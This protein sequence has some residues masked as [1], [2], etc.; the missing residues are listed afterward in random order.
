MDDIYLVSSEFL[1]E[2]EIEL[3]RMQVWQHE[4][5]SAEAL[6]SEQPFCLDMLGFEQWL[7]FVF[8]ER[9]TQLIA[10]RQELPTKFGLAPMSEQYFASKGID[11]RAL[12]NLLKRLDEAL[13]EV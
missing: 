5:P 4:R 1:F 12:T 6:A 2:L 8:I 3:K 13:S 9:M 7:Q 10:R 11:S